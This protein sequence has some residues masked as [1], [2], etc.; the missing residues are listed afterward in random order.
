MYCAV[1]GEN[2]LTTTPSDESHLQMLEFDDAEA[3]PV[4]KTFAEMLKCCLFEAAIVI[5]NC[6]NVL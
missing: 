6:L 1:K 3:F 4:E 5:M 2:H